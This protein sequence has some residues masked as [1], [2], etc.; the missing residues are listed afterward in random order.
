LI[1]NTILLVRHRGLLT[2]TLMITVVIQTLDITI[3]NVAIPEMQGSL[4]ATQ[5][6]IAWVLTS[7]IV[8]T[9]IVTPLTGTLAARFGRRRLF[10]AII[11][12]FTLASM[13]CGAS[14]SLSEIVLCRV[15]QGVFGALMP[16]LTQALLLDL[17]AI[18]DRARVMSLFGIGVMIGPLLGPTL[19]SYLTDAMS[20]RAV[21]YVNVPFGVLAVLG[22]LAYLPGGERRGALRF[23]VLGFAFLSLAIGALQMMLDR[24]EMRDWLASPE[25]VAELVLAG[26]AFYLF[27]VHIA[28]ARAPFLDLA[29]FHDRNMTAG[30]ILIFVFGATT[31]ATMALLPPFL[32]A[33][34]GYPTRDI[35]LALVPRGLGTTVAMIA[36]GKVLN[37]MDPRLLV[38]A[39][40]GCV[41]LS[42]WGMA[43][44][45]LIMGV[46]PIVWTGIVQGFGLGIVFMTLTVASFNTL[47]P[48]FRTDAAALFTLIKNIGSSFGVAAVMSFLANG[49]QA[50][51]AMLAS[52]VTPYNR[53]LQAASASGWNIDLPSGL[54]ALDGEVLRQAGL[55]GFL[56]D[57]RLMA[58]VCLI[59]MPL[60]LLFQPKEGPAR[61]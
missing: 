53:A 18:E 27:A 49:T 37:R 11:I 50:S 9:A 7:Y 51:H 25:I 33:L 14:G 28:T 26:L 15:L 58:I 6:Q 23:D 10:I 12:G 29:M 43:E 46:W 22:V 61:A 52:Y 16:P 13:A 19:G 3:A 31:L 20:W 59:S 36:S 57:F 1:Q 30:L 35:G 2:A 44:F 24:G 8:A 41:A 17:Y 39:G 42:L 56:N 4:S 5:D 40:T 47:A 48:R 34:L 38:L 54:A 45:D 21:F 32:S 55:I 60:A